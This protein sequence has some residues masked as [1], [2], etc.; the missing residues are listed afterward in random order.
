MYP[1]TPLSDVVMSRNFEVIARAIEQF[2]GRRIRLH[3]TQR[4]RRRVRPPRSDRN[5]R[6][7]PQSSVALRA[8]CARD[9]SRLAARGPEGASSW[10]ARGT[11]TTCRRSCGRRTRECLVL[12]GPPRPSEWKLQATNSRTARGSSHSAEMIGDL[13]EV[14]RH[15]EQEQHGHLRSGSP[16]TG[17]VRAR[18]QR[19]R[20]HADRCRDA[21]DDAGHVAHPR[22]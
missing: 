21:E 18:H 4:H 2:D 15:R 9:P 20:R 16:R 7:H 13:R 6:T 19:G 22:R 1:L 3:A 14:V 8:A 12:E 11:R 10:S 5:R 17:R